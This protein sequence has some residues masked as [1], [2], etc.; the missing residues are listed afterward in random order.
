MVHVRKAVCNLCNTCISDL[1]LLL[2][3]IYA[4]KVSYTSYAEHVLVGQKWCSQ[5]VEEP[6]KQLTP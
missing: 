4:T 3:D 1:F 5:M 2:L 6:A